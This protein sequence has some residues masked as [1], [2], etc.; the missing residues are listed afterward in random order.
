MSHGNVMTANSLHIVVPVRYSFALTFLHTE[1]IV[2]LKKAIQLFLTPP[3][4]FFASSIGPFSL[5]FI[6][7]ITLLVEYT[8]S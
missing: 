2:I 6:R 1:A 3:I 8:A 5:F 7:L 4:F